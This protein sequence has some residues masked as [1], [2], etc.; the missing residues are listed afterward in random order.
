MTTYHDIAIDTQRWMIK[1]EHD[2]ERYRAWACETN[3]LGIGATEAE[4]IE[5]FMRRAEELR[6]PVPRASAVV[7]GFRRREQ[8]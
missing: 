7:L 3:A 4:A 8:V 2:G 6:R 1:I 5:R